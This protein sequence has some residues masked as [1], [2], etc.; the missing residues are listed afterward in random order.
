MP[1]SAKGNLLCNMNSFCNFLGLKIIHIFHRQSL[2]LAKLQFVKQTSHVI[3][4]LRV[5]RERSEKK[6]SMR[7]STRSDCALSIHLILS[8]ALYYVA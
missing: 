5:S 3:N 7:M 1:Q 6:N 2:P 4:W 8:N